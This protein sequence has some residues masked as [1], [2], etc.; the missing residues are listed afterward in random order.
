MLHAVHRTSGL[1]AV[2]LSRLWCKILDSRTVPP[3]MTAVVAFGQVC[4][5]TGTG[6]AVR[7]AG[8]AI[9]K[10]RHPIA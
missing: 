1:R 7:M 10:W 3:L 2:Q 9:A 6:P 8:G 4:T 5:E